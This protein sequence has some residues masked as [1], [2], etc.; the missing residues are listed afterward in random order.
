MTAALAD[1]EISKLH[2]VY[3]ARCEPGSCSG[4]NLWEWSND[5]INDAF[6]ERSRL[7]TAT[8]N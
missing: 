7:M 4:G 2:V 5:L 3:L 8:N 6:N 1:E